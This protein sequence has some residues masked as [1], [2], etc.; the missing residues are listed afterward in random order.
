VTSALDTPDATGIMA[1]WHVDWSVVST[2][3]DAP[4]LPHFAAY[5]AS[6][7]AQV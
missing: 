6:K 2:P 3:V 4:K 5:F 1:W 7:M